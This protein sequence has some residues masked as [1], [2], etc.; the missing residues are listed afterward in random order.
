MWIKLY[1]YTYSGALFGR[2]QSSLILGVDKQYASCQVATQ[3]SDSA[4]LSMFDFTWGWTVG[5]FK[6]GH[7]LAATPINWWIQLLTTAGCDKKEKS[8]FSDMV[9]TTSLYPFMNNTSGCKPH[10]LTYHFYT[11]KNQGRW[12]ILKPPISSYRA[13]S[14]NFL[15]HPHSSVSHPMF[16]MHN[17]IKKP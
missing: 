14:P 2:P 7:S 11:Q 15:A 9:L 4:A 17:P 8:L 16:G 5:G 13:S 1:I 12:R 10:Q 3:W 6:H